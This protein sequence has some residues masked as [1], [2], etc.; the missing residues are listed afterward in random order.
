M[1]VVAELR[2]LFFFVF[3]HVINQDLAVLTYGAEAVFSLR[4]PTDGV[5]ETLVVLVA[6][7]TDH[8]CWVTLVQEYH[9]GGVHRHDCQLVIVVFVPRKFKQLFILGMLVNDGALLQL[10]RIENAD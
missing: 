5:N 1:P 6:E 4:M 2:R 9:F 7:L 8:L 3:L 10:A